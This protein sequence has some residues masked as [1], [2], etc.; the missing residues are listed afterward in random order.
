[1]PGSGECS[2][3]VVYKNI[4]LVTTPCAMPPKPLLVGDAVK[5][6]VRGTFGR[7]GHIL[8]VS[9][10]GHKRIFSVKWSD[11]SI[12][13]ATARGISKTG[14]NSMAGKGKQKK[15][16]RQHGDADDDQSNGNSCE[17]DDDDGEEQDS[18]SEEEDEGESSS[19]EQDGEEQDGGDA[20]D[21]S[22][23]SFPSAC[24]LN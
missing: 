19:D 20:S 16:R 10:E 2:N 23:F 14:A 17:G 21:N 9:G 18:T 12:G 8:S 6:S 15:Q 4:H 1:M 3:V 22:L 7:N 5:S 24:A 11:N 13:D